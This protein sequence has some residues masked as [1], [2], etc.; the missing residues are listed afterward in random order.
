MERA[1][2]LLWPEDAAAFIAGRPLNIE[3]GCG[4]GGFITALAQAGPGDVF[5]AVERDANVA[6]KAMERVWETGLSNIRF[7]LADAACLADIL[8]CG[9]ADALYLNF[10]DPWPH[11]RHAHRRLTHRGYLR[12]Y[13]T[14]LKPDGT[15]AFKTDNGDL[16]RF[17]G[18]ELEAEGWRVTALDE[19]FPDADSNIRT[20]YETRFRESG[21]PIYRIAAAP[22]MF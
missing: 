12:I 9:S 4:M 5:L 11:R 14:L 7:L 16:F 3:I 6:V 17:T 10:S 18:R 1:A 20:E 13:Q 19:D 22:P 15:L 21:K 8:E 2:G